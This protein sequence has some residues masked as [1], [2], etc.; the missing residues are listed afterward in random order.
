MAAEGGVVSKVAL[1]QAS[2]L[3]SAEGTATHPAVGSQWVLGCRFWVR[4]VSHVTCHAITY[5][6]ARRTCSVLR[7]GVLL[8]ALGAAVVRRRRTWSLGLLPSALFGFLE[9]L[10]TPGGSHRLC[11]AYVDTPKAHG[12]GGQAIPQRRGMAHPHPGHGLMSV[13]QATRSGN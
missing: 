7:V 11:L 9:L 10:D 1:A 6:S 5:T 8:G 13:P 4:H 12:R 2:S 3:S